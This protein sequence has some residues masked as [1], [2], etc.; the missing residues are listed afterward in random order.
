MGKANIA[1]YNINNLSKDNF[2]QHELLVE[3][4]GPY[5][6]R[7]PRS[8]HHPHR[9]SFFHLV[10]FTKGSGT[11]SIDFTTYPVNAYQIYFMIPGQVHSWQF[12]GETDGYIVNFSDSLFRSFLV[13][14]HYLETFHFFSGISDDCI[15]QLPKEIHT[16]VVQLFEEM[17][18]ETTDDNVNDIIMTRLLLLQLFVL[19]EKAS[20][21][22]VNNQMV[23]HKQWLLKN[24]RHLIEQYY[25]EKRLPKE[26]ADMLF[27]TPNYL[28]ALCQELLGKTAGELIRD[29]VLLEAKR[30]L[31]EAVGMTVSEVSHDL[32]FLDNSYFNRF[33][34][35]Y[36]KMTPDEFRKKF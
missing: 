27:V 19:V 3:R 9:H 25:R 10:L 17:I 12:E 30:L 8:L 36:A 28:N 24:F 23:Q 33:F 13:D 6:E 14:P 2:R 1:V 11:H 29:R 31:T 4:F 5:L 20:A 21:V 32:N 22:N 15:C 34:K 7:H 18:D 26:Y 35:K 16:R